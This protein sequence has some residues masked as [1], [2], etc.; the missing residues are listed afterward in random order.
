MV[1]P[2]AARFQLRTALEL[3]L[4]P[5]TVIA[6]LPEPAVR[7]SGDW[8]LMV[9]MV[10]A[11]PGIAKTSE[12]EVVAPLATL[13]C[14]V[15]LEAMSEAG[16]RTVHWV[17]DVQ[18]VGLRGLPFQ[19]MTVVPLTKPAPLT[20]RVKAAPPAVVERGEIEVRRREGSAAGSS[21]KSQAPRPWVAARRT[22]EARASFRE[23]TATRGR[24]T[25]RVDQ[26]RPPFDVAKTPTSVA[27]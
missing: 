9:V 25:E 24:P 8:P 17:A 1:M 6:V 18:V 16:I 5:T 12:L 21:W 14:A 15:P 22:R 20:V 10:G 11:G 13:T 23:R 4:V 7:L 3:K 26:L 19:R 27:A 2:V